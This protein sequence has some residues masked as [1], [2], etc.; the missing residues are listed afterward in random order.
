MIDGSSARVWYLAPCRM[1][2]MMSAKTKWPQ[3]V[4]V[5]AFV[6]DLALVAIAE[7]KES[8]KRNVAKVLDEIFCWM[9][10]NEL[11]LH[12]ERKEIT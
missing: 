1:S 8:L 5:L 10:K 2:H 9:G 4:K 3:G 6:D 7:T 11:Q 12:I